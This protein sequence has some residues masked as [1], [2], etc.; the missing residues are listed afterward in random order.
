MSIAN[1]CTAI[2]AWASEAGISQDRD[3]SPFVTCAVLVAQSDGPITESEFKELNEI[4]ICLTGAEYS[5]DQLQAEVDWIANNGN[6]GAVTTV[7]EQLTEE[8]DRR[9]AVS[10]AALIACAERG[11]GAQ[12]GAALQA[13]GQGLGFSHDEVLQLLGKAMNAAAGR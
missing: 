10:F 6:D 7:A 2:T 1:A 8:S 11:V 3:L 4:Q 5:W 13:L 12:E 9:L